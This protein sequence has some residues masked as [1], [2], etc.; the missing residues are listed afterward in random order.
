MA[1]NMECVQRFSFL[2]KYKYKD[3]ITNETMQETSEPKETIVVSDLATA[4]V[5]ILFK[6]R[7]PRTKL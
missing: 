2:N 1:S 7:G 6:L 5:E 4:E 3:R